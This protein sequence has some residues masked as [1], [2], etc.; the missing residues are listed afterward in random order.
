MKLVCKYPRKPRKYTALSVFRLYCNQLDDIE[1]LEFI[2]L[3][4]A[5]CGSDIKPLVSEIKELKELSELSSGSKGMMDDVYSQVGD[6][7]DRFVDNLESSMVYLDART[8]D[9]EIIGASINSSMIKADLTDGQQKIV[10]EALER[11]VD[12]IVTSQLEA[13]TGVVKFSKIDNWRV[14]TERTLRD[15]GFVFTFLTDSIKVLTGKDG[16]FDGISGKLDEMADY[17]KTGF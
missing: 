17:F 11:V 2:K 12:S 13:E 16:V 8:T 6:V 3:M 10:K 9:L 1:M 15:A 4:G 14:E 7:F 5:G